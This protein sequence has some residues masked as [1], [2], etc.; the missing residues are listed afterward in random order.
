MPVSPAVNPAT[1]RILLLDDEPFML[2]LLSRLLSQLGY[3]CVVA[4][5]SGSDA[6][7]QMSVPHPGFDLIVLDI[8]MPDMDG[9][10]FIRRLGRSHYGGSVVLL[11][12]E[13]DRMLES[14]EK[15]LKTHRLA[16]L[17]HLQK[18]L[19]RDAFLALM[20]RLTVSTGL[21]SSSH[22]GEPPYGL[23]ELRAALVNR[24]LVNYYQPKV[25]LL[26]GAVVG[27]ECL[28]RWDHPRHGLVPPDR[29]IEAAEEHNLIRELSHY[30]LTAAMNQ[31]RLWRRAGQRFSVAVNISM[32][33][34]TVLDF[35]DVVATMAADA[36]IEPAMIT[37]EVTEG[38]ATQH[39][40]TTLD[41]LSRLRLKRF[42]LA[43]DDFGIG[44]STLAKLRDLPFDEIK[45]DGGFVHGAA[46]D[47]TLRTICGA[48]LRM[49]RQ[50]G[51]Q[52]VAEGIEDRD[53]WNLVRQLGCEVGQGHF[54]GHPMP[55]AAVESWIADWRS[56]AG[57]YVSPSRR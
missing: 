2:E 21:V 31:V 24:E 17:G 22:G 41:V 30:V 25:S 18:P 36:G 48:S 42:R 39:F 20:A 1:V 53:D 28:V 51:M 57:R 14:I 16:S 45:I 15:L 5:T 26:T 32:L 3:R 9:I 38:K 44:H 47:A 8:N 52:T 11:S 7:Q 35:P 6:I 10:E 19:R 46:G 33:D 55:A 12:G 43:I 54:I 37:L 40:C 29:F 56:R 23:Q 4:C 49:A 13:S 34:L 50:L 27:M